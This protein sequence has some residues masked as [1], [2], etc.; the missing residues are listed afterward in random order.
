MHLLGSNNRI[1]GN[2]CS[3]NQDIGII[4]QSGNNNY[5]SQNECFY[6]R[7]GLYIFELE[8]ANNYSIIENNCKLNE[9]GIRLEGVINSRILNNDIETSVYNGIIL[10]NSSRNII[11]ENL[12]NVHGQ[13]GIGLSVDSNGNDIYINCITSPLS[14]YDHGSNNNWDNGIKGNFWSNYTGADEDGNGIGD[15]PHNLSGSAGSQDKFPLMTCPL[16]FVED[17]EEIPSFNLY[18]IILIVVFSIGI[19]WIINRKKLYRVLI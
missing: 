5:L 14:A 2:V 13:Y 8:L 6:A 18:I 1:I 16:P 10:V 4:A 7:W 15:I 19:I 12:V 11:S 3:F 9:I 17:V